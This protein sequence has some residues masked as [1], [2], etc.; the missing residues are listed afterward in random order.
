MT[1]RGRLFWFSI[2]GTF[3]PDES[4]KDLKNPTIQY[5]FME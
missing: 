3:N 5:T 2:R 4:L 1:H